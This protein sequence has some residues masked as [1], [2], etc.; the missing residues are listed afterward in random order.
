MKDTA[1]ILQF[2]A[3]EGILCGDG[4]IPKE[5]VERE[6]R[7][8]ESWLHAYLFDAAKFNSRHRRK[9]ERASLAEFWSK[10]I[11]IR[12]AVQFV[13][14]DPDAP[15]IQYRAANMDTEPYFCFV[16]FKGGWVLTGSLHPCG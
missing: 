1:G 3:P 9:D 2:V 4:R 16:R 6:L 7:D 14:R 11:G 12:S 13:G 8:S 10:G 5:Q 15:C